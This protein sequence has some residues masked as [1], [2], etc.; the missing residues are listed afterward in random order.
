MY[1]W[2]Y[3]LS[4][5]VL[6]LARLAVLSPF[7]VKLSYVFVSFG[8]NL[9]SHFLLLLLFLLQVNGILATGTYKSLNSCKNLK[10][11]HID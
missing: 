8:D 6:S 1:L 5:P 9:I 2:T 11:K 3:F 4:F 7:L 10:P